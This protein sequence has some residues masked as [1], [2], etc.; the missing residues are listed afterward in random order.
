[1]LGARRD[2]ANPLLGRRPRAARAM[3]WRRRN[4]AG[5]DFAFCF[6]LVCGSFLRETLLTFASMPLSSVD[7][8]WSNRCRQLTQHGAQIVSPLKR[9]GPHSARPSPPRSSRQCPRL[10]LA[11]CAQRLLV[12]GRATTPDLAWR[13]AE[14]DTGPRARR[15]RRAL[16]FPRF[17]GAPPRPPSRHLGAS[18]RTSRAV[19]SIF[20]AVGAGLPP[21]RPAPDRRAGQRP[22]KA[23]PASPVRSRSPTQLVA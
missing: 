15:S 14:S 22:P 12:P 23:K 6:A 4:W 7:F 13:A 18:S 17:H 1:M 10:R 11:A 9:S 3:V 8:K 2:V 20:W 5:L 19:R 21:P 16:R